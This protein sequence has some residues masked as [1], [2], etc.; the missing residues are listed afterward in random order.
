MGELEGTGAPWGIYGAVEKDSGLSL[1]DMEKQRTKV[2]GLKGKGPV[3]A[4][5]TSWG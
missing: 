2:R 4:K 3:W 1:E 5:E